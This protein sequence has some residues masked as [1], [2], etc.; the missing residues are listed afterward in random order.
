MPCR[1]D[2][3]LFIISC[4]SRKQL[5]KQIR[6]LRA[7]NQIL[8]SKIK[9][10]IHLTND[11][12]STLVRFGQDLG[13]ATAKKLISI[14]KPETYARWLR[15]QPPP[16]PKKRPGPP[17][18]PIE[19]RELIVRVAR[20]CGFGF[21]RI[22]GELA[23]VGV[24]DV[25]KSTIRRVLIEAGI[26]P[27][28]S[29]HKTPWDQFLKSHAETLWACDFFTKNV[30]T[31]Y[32]PRTA[33][34]LFFIHIKSRRVI[35]TTSTIHPHG[36]WVAHQ[37]KVFLNE[38]REQ[39]LPVPSI[40]IRDGDKKFGKEFHEV[41]EAAGCEAKQIPRG[42]PVMNAHAERW[43]RSIKHECLNHFICFS[44]EHL[45]HLVEQYLEHYHTERPHQGINN[46]LII[47]HSHPPPAS[48][49]IVCK[50]RLGGVLKSY[51]RAAA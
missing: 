28:P 21:G 16:R 25:S 2:P 36:E 49:K 32:G 37:A 35:A 46:R 48:G 10:R 38:A 45:D 42:T 11:E 51:S 41:L 5:A 47:P 27:K 19:I 14:V 12:R 18:K 20:E 8:K 15:K 30:W 1:P 17:R 24:H 33:Y 31:R 44:D 29:K 22:L 50:T 9:G 13:K 34:V 40:L 4:S 43:V 26:G 6:F 7:E 23:K 39:G 3:T